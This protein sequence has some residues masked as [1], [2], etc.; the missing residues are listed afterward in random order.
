MTR[1]LLT[2]AATLAAALTAP[3]HFAFVVPDKSGAKAAV[4]FSE[5]LESDPDVPIAR[6][7]GL[8][9]TL[10]DAAGK[11]TPLEHKAEKQSL[12]VT[13]PGDGPRVVFGTVVFGVLQ[14]GDAKPFLLAY[15]PKALVGAVPADRATVG[16]K[17]PAELVPVAEA[18][19]VRLKLVA[20]GQ[21]VAGAEVNLIEPDGDKTKLK[22]GADG[23]T[24]ALDG[25]GQF[26]AWVRYTE[27]KAGELGGKKYEEVRHYPTLVVSVGETGLPPLPKAVSS[28]GAITCDGH[29]YVYG[30][31]GGK[32]HHYDTSIV[33][34]TFQRVK[35]DGGTAWEKLPG[36]PRVQGMN[37]AAH[38]GKVY[39]AGGMQPRNAPGTPTDNVSI[40]DAEVFD[41][42][43]GRW[44]KLP[45]LPAPRSSHDLVAVGDRLVAVGGWEMKGKGTRTAWHD[46]ALVLDLAAKEPKWEAIPQ[47]FQR[48][49]LAAA[50]V[51]SKVYVVGGMTPDGPNRRVDVLDLETKQW[52]RGPDLPGTDRG[53]FAPAACAVG[54]KVV[55]NTGAGPLYRLNGDTWEQVGQAARKRIVGRLL[56]HGP[57]AVVLVGG[58]AG[59]ENVAAVEVIRLAE[60]GE[61]VAADR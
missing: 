42:A 2:A 39:R 41:P 1:L 25:T 50:V 34:D 27:V 29:L 60:V 51:G 11:D 33:L 45:P 28:L 15:H 6:V 24:A 61:K 54:G 14:K 3:A 23:L 13:L 8:K 38:G 21:P 56:P 46:T 20:G 5:D 12:A 9:L 58:A 57:D 26:G 47:P 55:V 31:H 7:A 43:S 10:R 49:A 59:G 18:G 32:T 22:T 17:L 35:L 48:R 4:V 19:K 30:G 44:A 37:L 52:S 16:D 36:G 40:A 53:A